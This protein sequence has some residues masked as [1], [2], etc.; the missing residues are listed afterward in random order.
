MSKISPKLN[1]S[2]TNKLKGTEG[3]KREFNLAF[4]SIE[5]FNPGKI[6]LKV[7]ILNDLLQRRKSLLDLISK[8]DTNDKLHTMLLEVS[9]DTSKAQTLIEKKEAKTEE[10]PE[11]KN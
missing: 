10:N 4:E 11:T 1:L 6:V 3:E 7:D 2:V 8:I 5:D 9:K